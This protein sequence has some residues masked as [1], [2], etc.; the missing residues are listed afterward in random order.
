[1][2]SIALVKAISSLARTSNPVSSGTAVIK[3]NK[4][5]QKKT[6]PEAG[7]SS[8]LRWEEKT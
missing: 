8:L 7:L 3:K 4:I 1:M 6:S 5:E 2:R